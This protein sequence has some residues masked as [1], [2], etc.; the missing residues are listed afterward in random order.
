MSPKTKRN[1]QRILPFGLIWLIFGLA[2][3]YSEYAATDKFTYK[4]EGAISPT[5]EI[6][7]VAVPAVFTVGM[8]IGTLEVFVM[9]KLL[10]RKSFKGKL[11]S[12][13]TIYALLMFVIITITYPIV[14]SM[15]LN[16]SISDADVWDMYLSFLSSTTSRSTALQMGIS[17]F[18]S[19]FY[20]EISENI[21]SNIMYNFF[22]GKYHKPRQEQRI[23][24]F[25]DMKSSTPIAEILGHVA[26][27]DL[28]RDYY[29]NL[30]DAIIKNHGEI[31]QYIGD[32]VVISWKVNGP[33]T[34]ANCIKCYFDMKDALQKKSQTFMNR[35]DVIP[36]FKA[37]IHIGDVTVGEVG[38]LKKEISFSGDV[39]NTTSR[40]QGLCNVLK[41]D[42]L[43]SQELLDNIALDAGYEV[44]N[45]GPQSLRGKENE[46]TLL[47][48]KKLDLAQ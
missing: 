37:G 10:S 19:L 8:I 9:N 7:L 14:A 48:I 22:T 4:P 17:L 5:W 38:A 43:I 15:Q 46:M 25:L 32:E 16:T 28:L 11:L 29:N 18:A 30:T 42:L 6:F 2:F 27:F 31:Y 1:F 13:L 41:Q 40:I 44:S 47:A 12:K 35:Y 26:Y 33:E 45:L 24:M 36:D 3:L 21:G 23:F 20:F 39:L 34:N